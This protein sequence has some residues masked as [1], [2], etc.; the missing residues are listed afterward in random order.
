M[1]SIQI[2]GN[3]RKE[4]GKKASKSI[5]NQGNVPCELYGE[6]NIHFYSSSNELKKLTH[7]DQTYLVDIDL[8]GKMQK[9]V[10][11]ETQYHPV[12]DQL[13]HADFE[14]VS[15]KKEVKVS[16]PVRTTG[17]SQGVI[18]GGKLNTNMRKIAVKG[19]LDKIPNEITVD[20][21]DLKIGDKVRIEDINLEG[22][23]LTDPSSN[24]V[25]A[26]ATTRLAALA[27][28]APVEGEAA[29]GGE[30]KPAAEAEKKEG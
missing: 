10:L 29:E 6:S 4:V 14:M 24:V 28:D 9:A 23:E 3:I 22:V 18:A 11:R 16:L 20:I 21:T 5:R 12:T 26:V 13:L 27:E 17:V 7:T 15:D 25:V 2:K 19:L 8:D 30:D 1:Q